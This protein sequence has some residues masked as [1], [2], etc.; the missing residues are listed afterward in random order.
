MRYVSLHS[1]ERVASVLAV[2][3]GAWLVPKQSSWLALVTS[4][5][6]AH[7][8]LSVFYSK[9]Q[10]AQVCSQPFSGALFAALLVCGVALF[11]YGFPLIILFGF[12]HVFNEVYLLNRSLK[13][14][15]G[16]ENAGLRTASIILNLM[17]YFAT[18]RS[19]PELQ[20]MNHAFLFVGVAVACGVF[21]FA[22]ARVGKMLAPSQWVDCCVFEIV[23]IVL[24]AVSFYYRINVYHVVLYHCIFW[25]VYPLQKMARQKSGE[26][27]RYIGL[28]IAAV[29][30]AFVFSPRSF[31]HPLRIPGVGWDA[32]F[33]FASTTHI[34]MSLGLS[35]AHPAWITRWFLGRQRQAVARST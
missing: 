31:V 20:F 14:R 17:L 24:L 4:V 1:A 9:K 23:G 10:I 6:L 11:W 18:V 7:Y 8:A 25:G 29:L 12:H 19:Y 35:T 3:A 5:G 26:T 22:L 28:N 21:L 27:G 16:P 2:V 13:L 15:E 30:I 33:R 34:L 32:L